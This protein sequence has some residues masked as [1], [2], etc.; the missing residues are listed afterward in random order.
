MRNF[1]ISSTGG[2]FRSTSLSQVINTDPINKLI[3]RMWLARSQGI[4]KSDD[5][6]QNFQSKRT[7]TL[8]FAV[9]I[10]HV[11]RSAIDLAASVAVCSE[12]LRSTVASC[13]CL[14]KGMLELSYGFGD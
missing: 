2:D 6:P 4:G 8:A 1:A 12:R 14:S 11:G 10:Q 13:K 3:V 9:D 5:V 7:R